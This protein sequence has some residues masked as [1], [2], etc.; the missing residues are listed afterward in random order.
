MGE[1]PA[2]CYGDGYLHPPDEQETACWMAPCECGH[3]GSEHIAHD[4]QFCRCDEFVRTTTHCDHWYDGE[5]CCQ[6]H[7]AALP[8]C[9]V[10]S[11]EERE[12]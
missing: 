1:H 4:C 9:P 12:A 7:A 10:C 11:T 8:K 2:G 6:C 3:R 5:A